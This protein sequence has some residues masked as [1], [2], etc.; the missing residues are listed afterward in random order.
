MYKSKVFK[1]QD[2]RVAKQSVWHNSVL[3]YI[4]NKNTNFAQKTLFWIAEHTLAGISIGM[5]SIGAIGVLAWETTK[6]VDSYNHVTEIAFKKPSP[7]LLEN[8]KNPKQKSYTKGNFQLIV[9]ETDETLQP[10]EKI[11]SGKVQNTSKQN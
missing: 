7:A 1:N 2:L 9:V 11:T 5:L 6:N 10:L 8:Q 4:F 3:P